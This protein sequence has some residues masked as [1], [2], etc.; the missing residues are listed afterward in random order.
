MKMNGRTETGVQIRDFLIEVEGLLEESMT[1]LLTT[2]D[3]EGKPHIRW[4]TPTLLKD[5]PGALY[6]VTAK[7]FAKSEQLAENPFVEWMIQGRDLMRIA[8]ISGRVNLIEN[9]SLRRE[10][11]EIIGPRLRVFWNVNHDTANLIVLETVME[12]GKFFIPMKGQTYDV[13]FGEPKEA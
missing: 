6:A 7:D 9:P 12:R 2:V 10:V 5:R 4:M 13:K 3:G 8:H 1:G 11:L